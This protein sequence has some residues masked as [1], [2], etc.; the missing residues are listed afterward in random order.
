MWTP[1][2]TTSTLCPPD[3]IHMIS[4]SRPSPSLC[5]HVL[6]WKQTKRQTNLYYRLIDTHSIGHFEMVNTGWPT[7]SC[8]EYKENQRRAKGKNL[9]WS[10]VSVSIRMPQLLKHTNL[11]AEQELRW[12]AHHVVV[13]NQEI[14]LV[15]PQYGGE[16]QRTGE[17][18]Q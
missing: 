6:Y 11:P 9:C 8:K 7:L 13:D 16:W 17:R 5:F 18:C 10:A 4:V 14:Q 2:P 1:P 3:F 12:E 15:I